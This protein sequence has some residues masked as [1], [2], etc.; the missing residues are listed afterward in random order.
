MQSESQSEKTL[1]VFKEQPPPLPE[2]MPPGEET[3]RPRVI[4]RIRRPLR[5]Q[6]E[7]QSKS[8]SEKPSLRQKIRLAPKTGDSS[9]PTF[10]EDKKVAAE[11]GVAAVGILSLVVLVAQLA[12]R[13][14]DGR[15]LREP[16]KEE[17]KKVADPI[18]R[19]AARHTPSMDSTLAKDIADLSKM[20]GGIKEYMLSDPWEVKA[21]A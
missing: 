13:R 17:Y 21:N 8:Q 15:K 4:P 12:L 9:I 18:G 2:E 5:D 19:I 16:T 20:T 6:N 1:A 11:L 14:K 7:S 10:I 3:E